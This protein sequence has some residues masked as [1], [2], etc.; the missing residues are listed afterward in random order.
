VLS[1]N[2]Q[3]LAVVVP[4]NGRLNLAVVDIVT[5]KSTVLTSLARHDVLDMR[6]VASE[7]LLFSVG[8]RCTP[9]GSWSH[10]G[11]LRHQP[12]R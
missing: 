9:T 8:D 7:R 4:I 5:R 1:L 2:G 10:G 12:R 11:R 6:W 3:H